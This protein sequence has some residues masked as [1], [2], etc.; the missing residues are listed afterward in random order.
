M[1]PRP[2][3]S[4]GSVWKATCGSPFEP[5]DHLLGGGAADLDDRRADARR[6]AASGSRRGRCCRTPVIEMSWGMRTP[7]SRHAT[8]APTANT[9]LV[10]ITA[11]GRSAASSSRAS[12]PPPRAG[13][14]GRIAT[15]RSS[16]ARPAWASAARMPAPRSVARSLPRS[17]RS[18]SRSAGGPSPSR[19]RVIS[20]VAARLSKPMHGC[21][22]I[23]STPQVST[24]GRP[25]LSS[26]AKSA[27][28]WYSPDEHERIHAMADQLLGH[29]HFRGKVVVVLGQHRR[30]ALGRRAPPAWRWSCARRARSRT[31][32]LRRRPC[33]SGGCAAPAPRRA[34]RTALAT[35]SRTSPRVFASTRSGEL[36]TAR[37]SR[38]RRRR[39]GRRPWRSDNQAGSR[40]W[41]CCVSSMNSITQVMSSCFGINADSLRLSRRRRADTVM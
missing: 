8:I 33:G 11:V 17:G 32:A 26:S 27:G 40:R 22:R 34:A 5:R 16:S 1:L 4:N 9:S 18:A 10:A 29:A 15:Q 41:R 6:A 21:R 28:S 24:Y 25:S 13:R 14:S 31:R 38:W 35:A 12:C 37:P 23:G 7:S 3:S 36:S 19:W 39:G 20:N 2:T 30:I